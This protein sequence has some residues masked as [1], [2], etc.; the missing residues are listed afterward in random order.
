LGSLTPHVNTNNAAIYPVARPGEAQQGAE[1]YRSLG[2]I[3]CHSQQ[4][5]PEGFGADISRGWGKRRSVSRDYIFDKP[6]QLGT[7]RTGPDLTNV[8]ERNGASDWNLKHLYNP[9]ITSPGSVMPAYPFLFV[10]RPIGRS[11]P[12]TNALALPPGFEPPAGFEIVAK[13]EAIQLVEYLRSLRGSYDLPEAT[14]KKAE[15]EASAPAPAAA[16]TNAAPAA[17]TNAPAPAK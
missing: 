7:S 5:R 10:K 2:C 16:G 11:G 12:S 9:Q 6:V 8:G 17:A 3:Y 14:I 13:P 1:V 15:G 4:V